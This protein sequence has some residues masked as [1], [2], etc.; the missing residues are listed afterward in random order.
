VLPLE[1]A[2]GVDRGHAAH[3]RGR[4]RLPVDLVAD[5]AGR[6]HAFDRR[7]RAVVDLDV[8]DVVHVEQ[9][10]EHSEFGL[11]PIAM[12]MPSIAWRVFSPLRCRS[13]ARPRP[14][15]L[16]A[17]TSSIVLLSTKSILGFG[18]ARSSMIFDARNSSRRWTTV[19]LLAMRV[20]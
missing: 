1:P 3:A 8:A 15:A 16:L 18:A 2:L 20:R 13:A 10:L 14:C 5:V 11:W 17:S 19:T 6:E 7:V 12:K 9:A 4:D